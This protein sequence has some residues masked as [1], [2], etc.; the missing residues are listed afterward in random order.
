MKYVRMQPT[1][2]KKK[3]ISITKKQQLRNQQDNSHCHVTAPANTATAAG[4][5]DDLTDKL[6]LQLTHKDNII[7]RLLS[8]IDD[9]EK[10]IHNMESYI[11]MLIT[12]TNLM[13]RAD[14][15]LNNVLEE[16]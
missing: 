6:L 2:K 14:R 8:K 15:L 13:V 7:D 4:T 11:N 10:T 9:Q 12:T 5:A 3:K 16:N 1:L